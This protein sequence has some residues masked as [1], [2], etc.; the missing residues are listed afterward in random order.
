M[1]GAN[2]LIAKGA[3][4]GNGAVISAGAVVSGTIPD[5]A[6]AQGQPARVVRF[7]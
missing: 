3:Q 2:A 1:L 7:R 4:I 5:G 6:V